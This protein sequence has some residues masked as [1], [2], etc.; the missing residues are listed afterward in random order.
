MKRLKVKF[1]DVISLGNLYD[2]FYL[3]A[4]AKKKSWSRIKV[5]KRFI[6]KFS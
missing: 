6:Y 2:S 4:R 3:V 5:R 1:K